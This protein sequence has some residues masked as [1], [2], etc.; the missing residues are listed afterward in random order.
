M[1][2]AGITIVVAAAFLYVLPDLNGY[3][4]IQFSISKLVLLGV[5][6]GVTTWCAGNFKANKHQASV[7]RFKAN[8]LRTFQAFVQAGDSQDVRDAVLLE[9]TRSIFAQAPSGFLK[10]ETH[11]DPGPRTIEI[12]RGT[13]IAG[14]AGGAGN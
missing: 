8:A 7:S 4:V 12:V 5:L 6:I 2:A 1:V 10:E 9:T 3:Q 11:G 14:Q 13:N